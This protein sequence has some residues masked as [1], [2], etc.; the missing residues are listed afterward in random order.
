VDVRAQPGYDDTL[1]GIR[2]SFGEA[3][4][5]RF[6]LAAPLMYGDPQ[7]ELYQAF[8]RGLQAASLGIAETEAESWAMCE[9]VMASLA[10]S[11]VT[12]AEAFLSGS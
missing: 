4:A 1:A 10:T 11:L 7:G 2:R 12:E 5:E 6:V 3:W 9:A 8:L